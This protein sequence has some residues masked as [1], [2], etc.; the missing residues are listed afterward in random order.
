[1]ERPGRIRMKDGGSGELGRTPQSHPFSNRGTKKQLETQL[2]LHNLH[3]PRQN[4][5]ETQSKSMPG[6]RSFQKRLIHAYHQRGCYPHV[7]PIYAFWNC[8]RL[9]PSASFS[10]QLTKVSS[11]LVEFHDRKTH[12]L[13]LW[14][15][16]PFRKKQG[17]SSASNAL[18]LLLALEA[19]QKLTL[20][21]VVSFTRGPS[22]KNRHKY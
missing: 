19:K 9:G 7:L 11:S 6:K 13:I 15:R 8:R 1:M 12:F 18:V 14:G 16:G 4:P 2:S 3:Q 10:N 20:T 17:L 22:S 21:G 5:K